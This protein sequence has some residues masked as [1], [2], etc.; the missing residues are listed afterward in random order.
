LANFGT[1][2]IGRK[3]SVIKIHDGRVFCAFSDAYSKEQMKLR[4][5]KTTY[6]FQQL[7]A[8]SLQRLIDEDWHRRQCSAYSTFSNSKFPNPPTTQFFP[9][10]NCFTNIRR[11]ETIPSDTQHYLAT[12]RVTHPKDYVPKP[13]QPNIPSKY[14][15]SL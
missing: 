3:F 10:A 12:S 14:P 2:S 7:N 15:R 11:F 13:C 8:M 4:M 1:L 9:I 6:I 5:E